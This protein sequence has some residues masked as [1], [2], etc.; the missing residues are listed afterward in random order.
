MIQRAAQVLT[1]CT[2]SL[3]LLAPARAEGHEGMSATQVA[4]A[5]ADAGRSEAD[6]ERDA[7]RKP[8]EVLAFMGIAEGMTV[9]DMFSGGGYYTEVL[10]AAVGD[11]GRV[12]AHN[13]QAYLAYA[14]DE[15]AKRFAPGRLGN[16]TR[17][18]AENN[19]LDLP[20]DTFDMVTMM[21][22][23]HDVY[24]VDEKN[25]WPRIDGPAMLA[26]IHAAMRP[27]AV[28][29][30]VD[31]VAAPGAPADSGGTLH[32]IDPARVEKDLVAAGFELEASSDA[33]HN[34][35]D[36]HAKPMYDPAVRGKTDRMVLRFR[37]PR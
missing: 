25:G 13:N 14:E 2:M 29:A 32:R 35:A 17:F 22:A 27:G 8:D 9:L 26:E 5:M 23:Y 36:D 31:H 30:V 28:L 21:L 20:A 7:T 16:V 15:L 3:V 6:R 12:H 19:E 11:A 37:K 1:I 24:F 10:A 33:L 4:A 18:A 34:P